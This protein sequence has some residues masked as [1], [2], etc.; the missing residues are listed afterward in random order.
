MVFCNFFE[1]FENRRLEKF[2]FNSTRLSNSSFFQK[3][4][5]Q[6]ICIALVGLLH[7]MSVDIGCG[8]DLSVSQPLGNAHTVHSVKI[9]HGGHC[10]PERMRVNV[11][12]IVPIAESL[13]PFRYAVRVHGLTVVLGKQEI[14]VLLIL[15][16][17]QPFPRLPGPVLAEQLHSL[18]RQRYIPPGAFC[19]PLYR[20]RA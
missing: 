4:I 19:F 15:P 8:A 9:Q 1:F 3:D 20:G 13:K 16:Q 5:R 11:R 18:R 10:V 2:N 17:P 7:H 14:L 12:E 6:D